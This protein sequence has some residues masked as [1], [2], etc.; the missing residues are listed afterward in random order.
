[1]TGRRISGATRV[2]GVAGQPVAHSLSPVIFNAWIEAAALD[3]VYVAFPVDADSLGRFVDGMR[4]GAM[5]A[6]NV[7]A[8]CKQEALRLADRATARAHRAGS[9]NLLIFAGDGVVSADTTDGEGLLAALSEQA[10]ALDLASGPTVVLG[11]GGAA[12][13]AAAAILDAGSPGVRIV[14]RTA[15]RGRVLADDLGPRARAFG[16]GQLSN[17]LGGAALVVKATPES[18]AEPQWE[19]LA[20]GAVAVDMV[21]R[22]LRTRFLE[23]AARHGVATVDGLAM[24]IGQARPSFAAIFGREPPG[25]DVRAVALAAAART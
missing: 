9:C 4:G 11:A 10:P 20:R 5:M 18:E 22:P 17:A 23:S 12:R 7:T 1:M 21:Y 6:L 14:N 13:A 24:L 25:L 8:P 19:R 3:A 16:L 2:L 15:V